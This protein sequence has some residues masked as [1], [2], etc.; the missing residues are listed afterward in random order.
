M[1]QEHKHIADSVKNGIVGSIRGTGEVVNAVVDTVSGT[2]VNTI[3]GTG[4]VGTAPT[5]TVSDVLRG[6]IQGTTQDIRDG[7]GE[8]RADC[9]RRSEEHTS[10]LQPHSDLVCCLPLEQ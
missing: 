8:R 3:K 2:L 4:A 1:A 6:A 10:E 7:R 5:S 9:A